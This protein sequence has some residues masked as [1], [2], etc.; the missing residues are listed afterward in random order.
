MASEEPQ[1]ESSV[2]IRAD[3]LL[4]KFSAV[5]LW[6]ISLGAVLGVVLTSSS[7]RYGDWKQLNAIFAAANGTSLLLALYSL[8]YQYRYLSRFLIPLI[9]FATELEEDSVRRAAWNLR[10]S[11]QWAF[12]AGAIRV[13]VE[14]TQMCLDMFL[15]PRF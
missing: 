10:A 1:D 12:I 13:V 8:F 7:G 3:R 9:F 14:F 2:D 6:S 4:N 5:W 11:V 15:E